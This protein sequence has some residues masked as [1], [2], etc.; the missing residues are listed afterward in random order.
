M[1]Q[2]KRIM[3]FIP[4]NGWFAE[5]GVLGVISF[6]HSPVGRSLNTGTAAKASRA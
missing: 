1:E 3:Q 5:M 4:A 2:I 6:T